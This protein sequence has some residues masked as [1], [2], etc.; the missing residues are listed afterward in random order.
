M[1]E[2]KNL[3]SNI[4]YSK[5]IEMQAWE[6]QPMS[7]LKQDKLTKVKVRTKPYQVSK[8]VALKIGRK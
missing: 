1:F 5:L 3:L 4:D 2:D 6:E 7:Y 8:T